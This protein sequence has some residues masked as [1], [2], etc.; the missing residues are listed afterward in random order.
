MKL[1]VGAILLAL[2]TTMLW[3][4]LWGITNEINNEY[5][6]SVEESRDFN[7]S[8]G[9]VMKELLLSIGL[10]LVS[11]WMIVTFKK[12]GDSSFNRNLGVWTHSLAITLIALSPLVG[13][14]AIPP[15]A[16]LLV[17]PFLKKQRSR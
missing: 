10:Y 1:K 14:F 13:L 2:V 3:Y 5:V 7:P 15:V 11:A 12:L 16:F 6:T 4:T 9:L 17:L 8:D